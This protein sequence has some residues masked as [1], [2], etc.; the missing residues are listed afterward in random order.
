MKQSRFKAF[1]ALGFFLAGVLWS[2]SAAA[3]DFPVAKIDLGA[4]RQRS[5]KIL[6]MVQEIRKLELDTQAQLQQISNDISAL[7]KKIKDEAGKLKKEEQEKLEQDLKV[8]KE[9]QENETQVARVRVSFKKKSVDTTISQQ[10]ADAIEK[11]AKQENVKIVL[12]QGA[13]LYAE[14]VKDIT[15][16]VIKELDAMPSVQEKKT[17]KPAATPAKN[18]APASE[19][20]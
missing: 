19:G 2:A 5:A 16:S 4:L 3:S 18:A 1:G 7:E 6:G 12:P 13:F 14:G 8:K 20:K 17:D 11:V 10:F 9:A 15:E